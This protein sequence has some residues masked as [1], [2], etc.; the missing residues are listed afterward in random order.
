MA[1]LY[2]LPVLVMTMQIVSSLSGTAYWSYYTSYCACCEES[3]NYDPAADTQECDEYSCCDY[4]GQFAAIGQQSFDYVQNNNLIA[5]FDNSDPNNNEWWNKYANKQIKLTANGITITA[6]I[7]DQCGNHDCNNCCSNNANQG[8]GYLVDT[9]YWTIFNNFGD[10]STAI[11][12]AGTEIQFEIIDGDDNNDNNI[13]ITNG[14][15]TNSWWYA[16]VISNSAE[17]VNKFEILYDSGNDW[18]ECT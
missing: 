6:T 1:M 16:G 13:I 7:V 18:F 3:P 10:P 2:F 8:G 14:I 4:V 12:N 15:D 17:T 9:E 5:F 11:G